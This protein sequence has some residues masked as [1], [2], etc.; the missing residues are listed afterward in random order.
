MNL[1]L[2]NGGRIIYHRRNWGIAY[3][4]ALYQAEDDTTNFHNSQITWAGSGWKLTEVDGTTYVF[5]AAGGRPEQ[6]A[7]IGIRDRRGHELRFERQVSGNL[8][9]VRSPG[10]RQLNFA[11]DESF[12]ITQ[13]HDDSGG[14]FSYSYDPSGH[15]LRVCDSHGRRIDYVYGESHLLR[16]IRSDGQLLLTVAY[17]ELGRPTSLTVPHGSS[18]TFTYGRAG[19]SRVA[20]SGIPGLERLRLYDDGYFLLPHFTRKHS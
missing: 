9:R 19:D 1:M 7:L 5:P 2:A 8:L 15:L 3:W 12:R 18:Y 13:I 20:V 10:G 6:G 17:D 11:Y 4:D 14:T 16:Q